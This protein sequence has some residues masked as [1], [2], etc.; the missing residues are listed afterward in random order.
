[1]EKKKI[2]L[3]ILFLTAGLVWLNFIFVMKK[4]QQPVKENHLE[5]FAD[6]GEEPAKEKPKFSGKIRDPFPKTS[7][8]REQIVLSPT[9]PTQKRK[10]N[11][12]YQI[13]GII[14]E[15]VLLEGNNET[16]NLK[17]GESANNITFLSIKSDSIKFRYE[18][19]ELWVKFGIR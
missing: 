2:T 18:D 9:I 11:F 12:P 19:E 17:K 13:N 4:S 8:N 16:F 3:L 5:H 14:G 10:R 7:A 1:M 15:T 6:K